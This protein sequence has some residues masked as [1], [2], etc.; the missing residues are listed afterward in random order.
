MKWGTYALFV[1]IIVNLD[2]GSY[3]R[4]T[5]ENALATAEQDK[6]DKYLHHCQE[7]R[8]SLNPM[9]YSADRIPV[10]EAISAHWCLYFLLSKKLKR[11]YLEICCFGCH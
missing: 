6:K 10:T 1:M 2:S 7:R 8:R 9:V 11:E 3:L 4:Q 5:S